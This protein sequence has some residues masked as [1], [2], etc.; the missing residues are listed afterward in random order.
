MRTKLVDARYDERSTAGA[1]SDKIVDEEGRAN[2]IKQPGQKS[3]KR[4][5]EIPISKVVT[6][7]A[8]RMQHYPST[9]YTERSE[10]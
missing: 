1:T 10:L 9:L 4:D 2:K 8:N 6:A 7:H 3:K 5:A